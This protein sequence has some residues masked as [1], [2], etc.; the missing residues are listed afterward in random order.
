MLL[1]GAGAGMAAGGFFLVL[2]RLA[3][4][5]AL[6]ALLITPAVLAEGADQGPP[7]VGSVENF[8][9]IDPSLPAPD[10]S[11][12]DV[13][14]RTISLADFRGKYL[15]LNLWATW[16]GPCVSEMPSLDRLQAAL[17][18]DNF[19]VLPISVDRGGAPLVTDFYD[20]HRISH[21]G[22]YVDP[23]NRI[24]HSMSVSGLPTSFLV[25]PDGRVV[26]A[27]VGA[28]DWDTPEAIALIAYYLKIQP[29]ITPIPV[30]P[31]P[32]P[33]VTPTSLRVA[34]QHLTPQRV[35]MGL[36]PL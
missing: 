3:L 26:G 5:T 21:L 15:L 11:F 27:L 19:A 23:S 9:R 10:D 13:G 22:V 8:S 7:I 2:K 6:A 36:S 4:S 25:G 32:T 30:A 1:A 31:A 29:N 24:A 28:T 17:G 34:P 12:A 18:S 35:G 16:C 20:K 14:G 33:Q